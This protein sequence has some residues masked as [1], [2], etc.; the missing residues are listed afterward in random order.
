MLVV[1]PIGLWVFSFLCDLLALFQGSATWSVVAFYTMA[2][3]IVGALLAAVPGFVDFLSIR[4]PEV[5]TV[6]W[7]HMVI[8]LGVVALYAV[9]LWLRTWS[10][11]V[12]F[13]P[14]A[15]NAIGVALLAISG[16]LG[17]ELV[18]VHGMGVEPAE[19]P[20]VRDRRAA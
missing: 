11:P 14:V 17:G 16:W 13:L 15:L 6:A 7:A 8:N 9:N 19:S 1:F 5:K 3:G 18:Y 4:P 10:P 20:G 2:G 12:V